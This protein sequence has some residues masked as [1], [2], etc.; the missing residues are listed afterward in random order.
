MSS[1]AF[2]NCVITGD[3]KQSLVNIAEVVVTCPHVSE[4]EVVEVVESAKKKMREQLRQR[5]AENLAKCKDAA[6]QLY[7]LKEDLKAKESQNSYLLRRLLR[8]QTVWNRATLS[9]N[10]Q[11]C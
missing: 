3:F 5:Q 10:P 2:E 6:H 8:R 1:S 11:V 4:E 9:N 7:C